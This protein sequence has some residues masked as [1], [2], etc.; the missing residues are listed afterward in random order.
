MT[1]LEKIRKQLDIID[2]KIVKELKKRAL[3]VLKI[4]KIKEN[5]KL[6]IKDPKREQFILEKMENKYEK[7]IFKKI[8]L[9][10]RKLQ[11]KSTL[12]KTRQNV[13]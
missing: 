3:L 9:E 1:K 7:E 11:A 5:S 4:K 2:S 10:S 13:I 8:L 12:A 6:Q